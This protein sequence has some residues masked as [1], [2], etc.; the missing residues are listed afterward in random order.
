MSRLNAENTSNPLRLP[1]IKR[2]SHLNIFDKI[3]NEYTKLSLTGC[4]KRIEEKY[5]KSTPR[6]NKINAIKTIREIALSTDFIDD[7]DLECFID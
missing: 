3:S 6:P 1:N 4:K 2:I 7:S 5:L